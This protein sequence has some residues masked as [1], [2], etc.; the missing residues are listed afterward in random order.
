MWRERFTR[1]P[2]SPRRWARRPSSSSDARSIFRHHGPDPHP[3]PPGLRPRAGARPPTMPR[4]LV[5]ATLG[6]LTV[7]LDAAVNI[8]FPAISAAFQVPATS[9]QWIVLT[10]MGTLA[11]ALIPAGRLADRVGH[12]RVFR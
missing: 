2:R 9:I 1:T 8:A 11:V 5:V 7:A 3:R 12:A 6:V 10:Y 4:P